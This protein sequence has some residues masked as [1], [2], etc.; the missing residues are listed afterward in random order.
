M[1][2][3]APDDTSIILVPPDGEVELRVQLMEYSQGR[4]G[5]QVSYER[6]AVLLA[7]IQLTVACCFR[8]LTCVCVAAGVSSS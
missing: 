6:Y 3:G 2:Q 4:P 5:S 1:S 8:W 7:D